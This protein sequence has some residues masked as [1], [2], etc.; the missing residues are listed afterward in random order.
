MVHC[1]F[2]VSFLTR[3][4]ITRR[5][6]SN[7]HDAR[8]WRFHWGPVRKKAS[9]SQPFPMWETG[10]PRLT[11]TGLGKPINED[12]M[13]LSVYILMVEFSRMHVPSLA[14]CLSMLGLGIGVHHL[15]PPSTARRVHGASR[16]LV[17]QWCVGLTII[18]PAG[19]SENSPVSHHPST[20]TFILELFG[21]FGGGHT[22]TY[23]RLGWVMIKYT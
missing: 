7:S 1:S 9:E 18:R 2:C 20:H 11:H 13:R 5:C 10:S 19:V 3:T 14:T 4:Q 12:N 23:V 22:V 15:P 21:H 8:R 17:S 16:C 6:L